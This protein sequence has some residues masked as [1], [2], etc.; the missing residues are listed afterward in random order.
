MN[1]LKKTIVTICCVG[2]LLT[3]CWD[4]VKIEDRGFIVG[5][6]IDLDEKIDQQK[7][8]FLVTN[9]FVIPSGIGSSSGGDT[10]NTKAYL[11]LTAN[12]RDIYRINES[13][14]S[15]MSKIPYFEHL[16]VIIVSEEIARISEKFPE[17]LDTFI[18][19]VHMRRNIKVIIAKE[20]NGKAILDFPAPE[21]K[22]PAIHLNKLLEHSHKHLGYLEAVSIG[23]IE[24][25]HL[26]NTSYVLPLLEVGKSLSYNSGVVI[27]GPQKKV[28]GNLTP[29]EM[30][31]IEMSTQKPIE[32]VISFNYK[33][34]EMAFEAIRIENSISINTK[35]IN[36][37]KVKVNVNTVGSLKESYG[38]LDLL[39]QKTLKDIEKHA[40]KHIKESIEQV[41]EKAQNE[42]NTDILKVWEQ[43][44]KKHYDTWKKI[45]DDWE[46]GE[47]YFANAH[48]DVEV[49]ADIYTI[50]T[51]TQTN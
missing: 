36:N 43:L 47:N 7:V 21:E 28:V 9:Q 25:A 20:N 48:F 44:E 22:I 26:N 50:G 30:Q 37:I 46:Q 23:D 35:D 19:D 39:N 34:N 32:Q 3:G 5:T 29:R 10:G 4:T 17:L 40:T 14:S 45:K 2:L 33:E 49:N 15:K 24:E 8:S 42:L 31:G 38:K 16:K 41:I 51:S 27:N 13:M 12:G 11:N 18:R 1:H 6:A